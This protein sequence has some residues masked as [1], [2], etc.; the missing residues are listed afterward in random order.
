MRRVYVRLRSG[1]EDYALDVADVR[2]VVEAEQITPVPGAPASALGVRMLQG[3]LLPVFDLAALLGVERR[4][5]RRIVVVAHAGGEVGL[6]A[7]QVLDVAELSE[8]EPNDA[9]GLRSTALAD[10]VLVGVIDLPSVLGA[11]ATEAG[12]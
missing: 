1:G 3:K 11:L 5:A 2:S 12:A 7:E 10:G 8:G 6:A 9:D 4:P